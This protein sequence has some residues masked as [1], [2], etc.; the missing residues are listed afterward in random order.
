MKKKGMLQPFTPTSVT[1]YRSPEYYDPEHY[2]HASRLGLGAITLQ[3]GTGQGR[4]DP[5]GPGKTSPTRSIKTSWCRGHIKASGTS[6]ILDFFLVKL[7]GWEYF[8]S[9]LKNN[10]LDAPV[11]R[12]GQSTGER[13]TPC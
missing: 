1:L 2:W 8:E 4:H 13:R 9:L 7:Y 3:Q 11:M 5:T 6:A 10:I 12:P